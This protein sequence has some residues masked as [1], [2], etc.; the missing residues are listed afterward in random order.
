MP[1]I[2]DRRVRQRYP[3]RLSVTC[4]RTESQF[5]WD[6]AITGE[7]LNISSKDLLFTTSETFLPGQAIEAFIDWPI[8]LDNRI[9]LTL[10]VEGVVVRTAANHAAMRIEK[11]QFKTSGVADIKSNRA[12]SASQ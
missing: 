8:L 12:G 2:S 5:S 1:D 7:S 3:L 6:P 9:R 11:Y 4:R 10:V